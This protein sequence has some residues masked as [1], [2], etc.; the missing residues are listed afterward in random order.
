MLRRLCLVALAAAGVLG[1]CGQD[2]WAFIGA[3]ALVFAGLL[4]VRAAASPAPGVVST[5]VQPAAD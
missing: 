3:A 2:N 5:A 4:A 1:L